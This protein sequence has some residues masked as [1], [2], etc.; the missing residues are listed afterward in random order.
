MERSNKRTFKSTYQILKELSAVWNDLADVTQ[1]NITEMIGGKRN[2]N[3]ISALLENF[4]IAEEAL[5]TSQGSE[6]SAL[7]ENE[8]VL[9]SVQGHLNVMNAS[10]EAL[11]SNVA[12]SDMLKFFIDLGTGVLDATNAVVKLVNACG[13]LK[14]ILSIV[15]AFFAVKNWKSIVS[16]FDSIGTKIKSVSKLPGFL[17]SLFSLAKETGSMFGEN[18]A[19]GALTVTE[20]AGVIA[21]GVGIISTAIGIATSAYNSW[22]QS[23]EESRQASIDAAEAAVEESSSVLDAYSAYKE[24]D[25]AYASNTG[26]K[27]ALTEATDTL[28]SALGVEG[29]TIDELASKYGSLNEAINQVAF[30]ERL[31]EIKEG[32]KSAYDN[33]SDKLGLNGMEG[34]WGASFQNMLGM[35]NA[36]ELGTDSQEIENKIK[37]IVESAGFGEYFNGLDSPFATA[38]A[39]L[40]TDY[41]S[42]ES[43]VEEY[44]RIQLILASLQEGLSTDE[45]NDSGIVSR[46]Q[47]EESFLEETLGDYLE[48][49]EEGNE[50][51]ALSDL[52]NE[53]SENGVPETKDELD[54]LVDGF[55]E[56]AKEGGDFVGTGEDIEDAY[57]SA[58]SELKSIYPEL[59]DIIDA[60]VSAS[61]A[62]KDYTLSVTELSGELSKLQT[63]QDNLATAINDSRSAVGLTAED[64]TNLTDAYKDLDGYD[65]DVLFED[66]ANGIHLNEEA[67]RKLNEE[68]TA[69]KVDEFTE[70]IAN[71]RQEIY[72]AQALGKDTSALEDEL[73]QAKLLRTE[74]EGNLS[75]YNKLQDAMDGSNERDSYEN[76]GSQ[77]EDMAK[78]LEQGWAG[79]DALNAYLD[80][81]LSAEQRTGDAYADFSKLS[82]AIEGTSHSLMDYWQYDD[83][84]NLVTDGLFDFL[85]DVNAIFGDEYA[86]INDNGYYFD[87]DDD[88]L[89][90]VAERF[91]TTTEMIELYERAMSDAGMA[92][93]MSDLDVTGDIEAAISELKELQDAGE[94]SDKIDL[95]FDIDNSSASETKDYISELEDIQIDADDTDAL[96][97][98]DEIKY[99]AETAYY[100]KLNAET[101]GSLDTAISIVEQMKSL[102]A[103]SSWN[104]AVKTTN[105]SQIES[106]ATE[107][108]SLPKDV[109]I[110]VGIS[111]ENVGNFNAIIAQ[112]NTQ[113]E[114][115]TVPV[116]YEKGSD[117][118]TVNEASGVAN[119]TVGDYPITVP[120]ASGKVN[121]TAGSYPVLLPTITQT[122]LQRTVKVSSADGTAH[123]EGTAHAQGTDWTLGKNES[124]LV[125]ELGSESIVRDGKWFVIPGGA[126][127]EKLRKDDIIFNA[128]QTEQLMKYGKI[129]TGAVHGRMALANGTVSGLLNAYDSGSGGRRR[130]GSYSS[131]GATSSSSG[132]S[133]SSYSSPSSSNT[134]SSNS[135]SDDDNSEVIDWIE[136]AIDRIERAVDNLSTIAKSA[137]HTLADKLGASNDELSQ[138]SYEL[139]LQQSAYNRYIQQAN[140]VGLSADLAN[141]VQNGTIDINE[142]DGDT[143]DKIK[144]YQEWYT[145]NALLSG[146]RWEFSI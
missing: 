127:I 136:I 32:Q 6:G 122:V 3:V 24:A 50:L 104:I 7:K 133:A 118:D 112:L 117:P 109:Q 23:V 4:D 125:N 97:A 46:L 20:K 22:R 51:L 124:S 59:S 10:F 73:E 18:G 128:N 91:G 5:Q 105:D 31:Q 68:Y 38:Q 79:D 110:A 25:S 114:S 92:I 119:Y 84:G 95:E 66:T 61:S 123:F 111:P 134:S 53:F 19:F 21:G 86:G 115:I 83:D 70:S 146:N 88:R 139:S 135:S 54:E 17:S 62:N 52:L 98:L 100:I 41:S 77:Y 63:Y 94:I 131:S 121:Y 96:A 42:V 142:Y 67:L 55:V 49:S 39:T 82:Q 64:I 81:L 75:A 34:D 113:P 48:L 56:A 28:L 1:A 36:V 101:D 71:L 45:Y 40:K 108:A 80:L 27:E 141:R 16:I 58:L 76:V 140:S 85:D 107:L 47:Q 116:N 15:T 69:S 2:A 13:G 44:K 26:S 37:S 29:T 126:H 35:F 130:S 11:S 65:A 87:F 138:L 33:A 74:L 9:D 143:A 137:F 89:E 72:Q 90:K 103:E 12:S 132:N 78:T 60:A 57:S 14:T 102:V 129:K 145:K 120:D 106:L 8:K 144:D 43:A 30:N 99:K 93:D